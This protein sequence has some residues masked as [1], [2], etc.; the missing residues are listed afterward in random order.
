LVNLFFW[1][2]S[3]L[4]IGGIKE[5]LGLRDLRSTRLSES[6]GGQVIE[7]LGSYCALA[8]GGG[9]VRRRDGTSERIVLR[10]SAVGVRVG[11]VNGMMVSK[12]VL[13]VL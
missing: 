8:V 4:G 3:F 5:G 13:I 9:G 6:R 12:K 1:G 10:M 11:I 7:K 2:R